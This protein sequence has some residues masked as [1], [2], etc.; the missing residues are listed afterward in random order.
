[1][2]NVTQMTAG[3]GKSKG[4]IPALPPRDEQDEREELDEQADQT[5]PTAPESTRKP[6]QQRLP[7]NEVVLAGRQVKVK[8]LNFS[9][10]INGDELVERVEM[11]LELLLTDREIDMLIPIRGHEL[12]TACDKLFNNAGEPA[13]LGVKK[14]PLE[15]KL[16]GQAIFEFVSGE[17]AKRFTGILKKA[18]IVPMLTFQATLTCQVRVDPAGYLTE[19]AQMVIDKECVF[20]F[21]GRPAVDED[22]AQAELGV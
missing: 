4:P 19:L 12:E 11:S 22:D 18:A 10:E 3:R 21:E 2:T 1:M 17:S 14:I 5:E 6:R 16:E 7:S 9:P 15:L 13:L 8:R 20:T